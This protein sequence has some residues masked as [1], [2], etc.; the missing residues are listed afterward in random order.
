MVAMVSTT[1]ATCAAVVH[2]VLSLAH[3]EGPVLTGAVSLSL[4]LPLISAA[5]F[6]LVLTHEHARRAARYQEMVTLLERARDELRAV[7]TWSSLTRVALETEDALLSEAVEWHA[8]RR[9]ASE[10]H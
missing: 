9:F 8:F 4:V 5:I 7:R 10:P 3:V 6:A 2:L 1:L